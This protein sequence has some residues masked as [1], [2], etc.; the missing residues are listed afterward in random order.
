MHTYTSMHFDK[1]KSDG[2]SA[3][4]VLCEPYIT[5]VCFCFKYVWSKLQIFRRQCSWYYIYIYNIILRCMVTNNDA[6]QKRNTLKP[7]FHIGYA[8]SGR[9]NQ[10]RSISLV[11]RTKKFNNAFLKIH[12]LHFPPKVYSILFA[13]IH[14][15]R[16][17]VKVK[18]H[19]AFVKERRRKYIYIYV[20]FFF[21]SFIYKNPQIRLCQV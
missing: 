8:N 1:K 13:M 10:Y 16:E 9:S 19:Y 21:F 18:T 20:L 3:F 4:F 11:I 15:L 14:E 5:C 7:F 6:C 2:C 12:A 17:F